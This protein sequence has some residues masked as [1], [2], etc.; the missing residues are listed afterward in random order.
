[1]SGGEAKT[2][3]STTPMEGGLPIFKDS[4][5]RS[6]D[7]I[8]STILE[9]A[10]GDIREMRTI[11]RVFQSGGQRLLPWVI[12]VQHRHPNFRRGVSPD[13]NDAIRRLRRMR[14]EHPDDN[15]EIHVLDTDY[16]RLGEDTINGTV[17]REMSHRVDVT[18][19]SNYTG[20]EQL[21][22]DL[23]FRI[24]T[25]EIDVNVDLD[26]YD[27]NWKGDDIPPVCFTSCRRLRN[28]RC[29][30]NV[31]SIGV[32]AFA[33][34]WN[35]HIILPPR[36]RTIHARAFQDAGAFRYQ[37]AGRTGNNWA[38]V[39]PQSVA[40]IASNAFSGS[41]IS[42]LEIRSPNCRLDS[43]AF[44]NCYDLVSVVF[45]REGQIH[46]GERAFYQNNA[47]QFADITP[48][49]RSVRSLAFSQCES[50]V[51]VS[52]EG[53]AQ[54][55]EDAY[56]DTPFRIKRNCPDVGSCVLQFRF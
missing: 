11:N 52:I 40:H 43:G 10:G 6:S 25:P 18:A 32:E 24:L 56:A 8:T 27:V 36:L 2:D 46:I 33:G 9:M 22:R 19:A 5:A 16:Y 51:D 50:L 49:I 7:D 37:F 53:N 54:I 47:L 12:Q 42:S 55:A 14:A 4:D 26:F 13:L 17:L 34:C 30:D 45:P 23:R 15:F 31:T 20:L 35:M 39:I 44:I 48:A 21:P 29:G 28:F 3:P 38:L 41:G 1:M